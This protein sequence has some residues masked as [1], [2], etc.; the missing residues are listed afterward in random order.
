MGDEHLSTIPEK[1]SNKSDSD[2]D[3]SSCDDFS[4]INVSERKTVTFSSPLFDSNDDFTSSD[5]ESL[6]DKD[7][8]EDNVKIYLNPLFEFDDKYISSD[9][10]PLFDEVL[11]NIESKDSYVS[12]FDEP[13]LLVTPLSDANEDDCFDP[14]GETNEIDAFLD[15][16]ISMDIE[17]SYHDS[18]GD[19]IYLETLLINDTI[20]NLTPKVFLDHDP[21]NLRDEPDN[22]VLKSMVKDCPDYKDSCNGYVK[23]DKNEAKQTKP[24]TRLEK[25]KKTKPKAY[26]SLLGQPDARG[27][28]KKVNIV[29][30]VVASGVDMVLEKDL[31]EFALQKMKIHQLMLLTL[32]MIFQTFSPTLHNPSTR[33]TRA[34]YVGM[35]LTMVMIV[36][37]GSCLS[38]SR[39][40]A[41]IKTLVIIIIHKIHRVFH[42]NI[43]AVRT[44]GVLMKIINIIQEDQEWISKLNNEF[45]ESVR[46]MFEE[47]RKRLQAAN[48]STHTPE[49]L[50]RF[51]SFYDDDDYKESTIPSNEIVSQ[52]LPSIA[53]TPVLP[54]LEPEDS[55]SMGD[56]Y[57]STIPEK[58][59]DGAIK[60]LSDKDVL[61]D[62][63]KIY[64]NPLFEFDDEYIS[65]DVNPLFNEVLENIES[66][67]SYVSNFDES[68]LLV[69]PLSDANE[70]ECFDPGGEINK[71]DAFLD[72]DISTD[73]ENDYHNSEGDIIYLESLLI[74]DTIPNLPPKVFLDHDPKNLRDEPDNEVLKSMVKVFDPEIHKKTFSPTYVSLPFENRH[75]LSLTYVIRIFLLYFTYPVNSSLP[76]SSGSEDIIFDPDIFASNFSSLEP[77]AYKCPMEVCTSTCFVPN[78]TMI[79][80][81]IARIMK[82]LVLVVLS[83]VHSIFNPSHAY[84]WESDIL[85]LID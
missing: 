9:V 6:S 74:N 36:H 67:D 72:M 47:F 49:P 31:V 50:R 80:G 70:D 8:L 79:L 4:P 53:I 62:N 17:N 69:T 43:F 11:E 44:V 29:N 61:E 58:E 76:P 20:P 32:S 5:D 45:I 52:K 78:I 19:I 35:I 12:N 18:E 40:R 68:A 60:F 27:V 30:G 10:N 23:M 26:T 13:A 21:K 82:T 56:E 16:D 85:D 7:V 64:S 25:C 59:S 66:K 75:Y 63:V 37:H 3:L 1:E 55:L 15:M 48:I 65:S 57:L 28:E 41:T 84:I 51:N 54:T 33:H 46:S 2:C 42:N 83:I 34:S 24:S 39:N 81:E 71:I 38:M 77:V 22:E 73:I 14:G